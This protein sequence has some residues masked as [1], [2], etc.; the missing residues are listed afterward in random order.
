MYK[1]SEEQKSLN[2]KIN[3]KRNYSLLSTSS[4]HR[5]KKIK[6]RNELSPFHKVGTTSNTKNILNFPVCISLFTNNNS[7][8][9]DTKLKLNQKSKINMKFMHLNSI[10]MKENKEIKEIKENKRIISRNPNSFLISPFSPK[11]NTQGINISN[12][13]K[14]SSPGLKNLS[15]PKLVKLN[16]SPLYKFS[17]QNIPTKNKNNSITNTTIEQDISAIKSTNNTLNN[18]KINKIKYL[19]SS[20]HTSEGLE[21]VKKREKIPKVLPRKN[22]IKNYDDISNLKYNKNNKIYDEINKIINESNLKRKY[23]LN[24]GTNSNKS[25]NTLNKNLSPINNKKIVEINSSNYKKNIEEIE[26][27]IENNLENNNENNN[28][29]INNN[30]NNNNE[31]NNK[32]LE[33][34]KNAKLEKRK[35]NANDSIKKIKEKMEEKGSIFKTKT[36]Q[37]FKNNVSEFQKKQR[38]K[39]KS[40][41][42]NKDNKDTKVQPS[43]NNT[44]IDKN[45]L[46]KIKKNRFYLT[47]CKGKTNDIYKDNHFLNDLNKSLNSNNMNLFAKKTEILIN[48]KNATEQIINNRKSKIKLFE[49][50]ENIYSYYI[51]YLRKEDPSKGD[52]NRKE[53]YEYANSIKKIKIE[54][55]FRCNLGLVSRSYIQKEYEFEGFPHILTGKKSSKHLEFVMMNSYAQL[56]RYSSKDNFIIKKTSF[57]DKDR[58]ESIMNKSLINMLVIQE[59]KLK[60][61]YYYKDSTKKENGNKNKNMKEEK[62]MEI[63][64]VRVENKKTMSFHLNSSKVLLKELNKKNSMKMSLHINNLHN[65]RKMF[66]RSS[67]LIR[68]NILKQNSP[69]SEINI[70]H[71]SILQQKHFFKKRKM[72]SEDK[73]SNKNDIFLINEKDN[74]GEDSQDADKIYIELM[75]LIFEGKSN[76]FINFYKKNKQ[77][78]DVD[79]DLFDGNTLLILSAKDGNFFITKFLCEQGAKINTQN[80]KGNTALHYAIG[81]Q[82]YG[83]ADVLARH[84]AKEEI[85]NNMGL[86]PWECI[87]HNIEE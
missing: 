48:F 49:S 85:R 13:Y 77:H 27:N 42:D 82:F 2:N 72:S 8:N 22:K 80:Q 17:Q 25:N 55:I 51:K 84:G 18:N 11:K 63:V 81:K 36:F 56:R 14:F 19:L 10:S 44:T 67:T 43:T 62:K 64:N 47:I 9:D 57:K 20:P 32:I 33:D 21:N 37:Q 3:L 65:S 24:I 28:N 75:K 12:Y 5:F 66:K 50:S 69:N 4:S 31:K 1:S 30:E 78:I 45:I 39:K 35:T 53:I 71:Y 16:Y 7:I 54:N 58:D 15:K 59:N 29:E 6:L 23:K 70:N 61:L 38:E 68:D 74:S 86:T 73:N 40:V 34:I 60:S 41:V 87:E 83:V 46:K 79:Q 52:K 26:T 76:S